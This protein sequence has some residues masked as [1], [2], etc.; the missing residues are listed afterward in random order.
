MRLSK[1]SVYPRYSLMIISEVAIEGP[2][3]RVVA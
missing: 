2:D 3:E 1:A